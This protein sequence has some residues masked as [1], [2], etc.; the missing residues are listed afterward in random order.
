MGRWTTAFKMIKA[1]GSSKVTRPPP[2][3]IHTAPAMVSCSKG[4]EP[5]ITLASRGF[6]SWHTSRTRFWWAKARVS[7]Y[8][9]MNPYCAPVAINLVPRPS[10]TNTKTST[11]RI[12]RGRPKKE[13]ARPP[14]TTPPTPAAFG[15]AIRSAS[16]VNQGAKVLVSGRRH[17][18]QPA[19]ALPDPA[20]ILRWGLSPPELPY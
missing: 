12:N 2:R 8:R 3:S 5:K 16:T 9:R 1:S 17:P 19:P 18:A 6:G 15:Q 10:S 20:L 11:S 13:A 4:G 7:L 14:I